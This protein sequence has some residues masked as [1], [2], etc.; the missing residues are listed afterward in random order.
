MG[1]LEQVVSLCVDK[2]DIYKRNYD[3]K[4][5]IL[6]M[7]KV[8]VNVGLDANKVLKVFDCL[9][10]LMM[11][12]KELELKIEEKKRKRDED[13]NQLDDDDEDDEDDDEDEDDEDDEEEINDDDND[14][15][16]NAYDKDYDCSVSADK[17]M[18]KHLLS[19]V[20]DQDEFAVFKISYNAMKNQNLAALQ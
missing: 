16:A 7:S 18:L 11:R 8:I 10:S 14:V 17:I 1:I 13:N 15:D 20:S 19:P 12:Q 3:M 6:S 5:F 4:L 2:L 9:I